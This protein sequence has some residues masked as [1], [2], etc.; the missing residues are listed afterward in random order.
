MSKAVK[1]AVKSKGTTL[2]GVLG[3]V[4]ALAYVLQA[5][6]DGDP[7]T[8]PEWG[9]LITAGAT[10]AGLTLARDHNVTSEQAGAE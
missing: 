2:A 9:V 8:V 6:L 4:G 7:S 3:F 10:L 1:A 5:A